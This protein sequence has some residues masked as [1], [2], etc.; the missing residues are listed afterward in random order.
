MLTYNT[1]CANSVL[2]KSRAK[3]EFVS[4]ANEGSINAKSSL[5]YAQR[6]TG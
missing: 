1:A 3:A 5:K 4:H 2:V 6:L